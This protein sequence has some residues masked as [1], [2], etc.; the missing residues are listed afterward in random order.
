MP[1]ATWIGAVVELADEMDGSVEGEEVTRAMVADLHPAATV[2]AVAIEDVE[3]P[4][5]EVGLR[6][7]EMRHDVALPALLDRRRVKDY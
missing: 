6:R 5:G 7:P 3:L 4:R 1:R 2:G